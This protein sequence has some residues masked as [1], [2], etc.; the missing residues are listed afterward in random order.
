MEIHRRFLAMWQ[1]EIA[2]DNLENIKSHPLPRSFQLDYVY[3]RQ[4]EYFLMVGFL[5]IRNM[6]LAK[7][8]GNK[9]CRIN[10]VAFKLENF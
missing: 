8:K 2:Y 7:R 10:F 4:K 5:R 3:M 9:I 1:I 6:S